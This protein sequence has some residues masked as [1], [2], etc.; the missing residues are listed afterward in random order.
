MFAQKDKIALVLLVL[1]V[2]TGC[3]GKRT[4]VIDIN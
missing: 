1:F 3:G 4:K 2:L